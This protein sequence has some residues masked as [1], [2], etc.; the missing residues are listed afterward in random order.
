[1]GKDSNHPGQEKGLD[2]CQPGENGVSK[3]RG[4]GWVMDV[5]AQQ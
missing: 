5:E 3:E 1:M 2:R 4:N